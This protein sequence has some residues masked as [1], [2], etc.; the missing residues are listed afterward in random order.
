MLDFHAMNTEE[1]LEE[2]RKKLTR[3]QTLEAA[4]E[5]TSIP[6][7]SKKKRGKKGPMSD[8]HKAKL[9][10]AQKARWAKTNKAKG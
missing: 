10:A 6:T 2:L 5:G 7:S 9:S 3:L 1:L 8:E 4:F